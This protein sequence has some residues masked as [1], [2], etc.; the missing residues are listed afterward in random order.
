MCVVKVAK[1]DRLTVREQFVSNTGGGP[2][3]MKARYS[4]VE[5]KWVGKK[6]RRE[7]VNRNPPRKNNAMVDA[8]KK[9]QR[10]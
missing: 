1:T 5:G 7:I 6:G 9:K 4:K 8:S 3:R 2:D 10:S